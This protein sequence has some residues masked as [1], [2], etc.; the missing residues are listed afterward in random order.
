MDLETINNF[1]ENYL[2]GFAPYTGENVYKGILEHLKKYYDE[3][4]NQQPEELKQLFE[5]NTIPDSVYDNVLVAI[6]LQEYVIDRL[7]YSDKAIFLRF[8]SDFKRYQ[9]TLSFVQAIATNYQDRMNIYEL[10][11]DYEGGDWVLKPIPIFLH[12]DLVPLDE[13]LD[14]LEIYN[15]VPTLLVSPE[16]LTGMRDNEEL[17]LPI[18][19]NL[20]LLDYD[21]VREANLLY[22]LIVTTFLLT[23]K[24]TSIDIYFKDESFSLPLRVVYF[25]WYYLL[26]R[27]YDTTWGR[28]PLQYLLL[29]DYED[30]TLPFELTAAPS[31]DPGNPDGLYNMWTVLAAYDAVDTRKSFDEFY[32]TYFDTINFFGTFY[33]KSII[34]NDTTMFNTIRSINQPLSDYL[35]ERISGTTDSQREIQI[36]LDEIYASLLLY[37]AQTTDQV[38]RVWV[39]YFLRFLPQILIDPE[40]T[41]TYLLLYNL[42]PFHVELIAEAIQSILVKDKFNTVY[43]D[44]YDYTFFFRLV[45]T[46]VLQMSTDYDFFQNYFTQDDVV[47]DSAG[48][49]KMLTIAEDQWT[50]DCAGFHSELCCDEICDWVF[51][52]YSILD[53][54]ALPISSN[55]YAINFIKQ[56]NTSY[57][58]VATDAEF[59]GIVVEE[60]LGADPYSWI[61]G[62]PTV[63]AVSSY[64]LDKIDVGDFI[65]KGGVPCE[66]VNSGDSNIDAVE[67]LS[68]TSG[69]PYEITLASNYS[70][71][72]GSSR[73]IKKLQNIP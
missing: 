45:L 59:K 27:H 15:K 17:V 1:F 46:S 66:E 10:Y 51:F 71:T 31:T 72:S 36:I 29:F 24:D 14:Y 69:A 23:Y 49:T 70:G 43:I 62:S 16:R 40:D 60:I 53:V 50:T 64:D 8:F 48:F 32:F 65:F 57:P 37:T 56:Y 34:D 18:K 11:A 22:H 5:E 26:T 42:K 44:A 7:S 54:S 2:E 28:I 39:E 3:L 19:T 61:N 58:I 52:N 67:V 38:W 47:I 41:T 21:L 6:G 4:Y 25:M 35:E 55:R 68:K 33:Q 63:S 20:L 13:T 73:V 9:G 30:I 12:E